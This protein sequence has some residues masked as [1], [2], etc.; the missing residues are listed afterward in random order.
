MMNKMRETIMSNIETSL[1]T[2]LRARRH[3][4][5]AVGAR[6]C[7]AF[8]SCDAHVESGGGGSSAIGPPGDGGPAGDSGV[9]PIPMSG[10]K[11]AAGA[12]NSCFL[13]AAGHVACWGS[14]ETGQL[15]VGD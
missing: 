7:A 15:G 3:H 11:I 14:A 9:A 13:S 4:W 1:V 10:P 12:D 5:R 2:F 6:G 8:C